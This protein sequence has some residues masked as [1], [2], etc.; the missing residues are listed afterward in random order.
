MHFLSFLAIGR[1]PDSV[2]LG[3]WTLAKTREFVESRLSI[4][5]S[6]SS[7]SRRLATLKHL[8]R[9]LAE[10]N[11]GFVNPARGVQAPKVPV[12]RPRGLAEEEESYLLQA[13]EQ[14]LGAHGGNFRALR[15]VMLCRLL[16]ATGIRADEARI[17]AFGQLSPDL[18]WIKNVRTKGRKFRNVYIEEGVRPL[19][20]RYLDERRL[21]L[22]R[23][24]PKLLASV[25]SEGARIPLFISFRSAL[26]SRPETFGLSPK[27][28]WRIISQLGTDAL[29]LAPTSLPHLH[30]HKLRHTFAHG[31]LAS[32]K[33]VRLVAQ[34]LGHGD[35]RTTMRYT[36]RSD[37][38]IA[39]AIEAK[40]RK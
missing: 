1:E 14:R 26:P 30:P 20:G 10:R 37:D 3:E 33:D 6:P 27:T 39:R 24:F 25:G 22:E 29:A 23:Q 7:V 15:D 12:V 2:T 21:E 9:A 17:L 28:V 11:P 35:V 8:G 13:C 40:A 4:G 34:A 5:E 38:E 16:L 19:L 31:L 32:V 36:E 18:S